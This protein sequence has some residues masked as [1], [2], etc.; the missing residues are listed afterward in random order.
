MPFII[1]LAVI[2]VV[3]WSDLAMLALGNALGI[4]AYVSLA[5]I[6]DEEIKRI[7]AEASTIPNAIA[8]SDF[9]PWP[10]DNRAESH[11]GI[12]DAHAPTIEESIP[13]TPSV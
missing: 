5:G 7:R 12:P 10:I 8:V 3:N 13:S 9:E 2:T 4:I 6:L 1:L 11:A